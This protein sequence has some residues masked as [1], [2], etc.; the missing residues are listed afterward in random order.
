MLCMCMLFFPYSDVYSSKTGRSQKPGTGILKGTVRDSMTQ[1]PL[2]QANI[3]IEGTVIG[4]VTDYEGRFIL[5]NLLPGIYTVRVSLLGYSTCV[6][7]DVKIR[8]GETTV[9]DINLD[10][11]VIEIAP[12]VVTASKREQV[13]Q[14]SPV[15]VEVLTFRQL[16]KMNVYTVDQALRYVSGVDIKEGE[17]GIRASTGFSQGAGSRVLLLVDGNPLMA[18]DTETIKWDVIPINDI[19]R[20]EIMKGAGSALYGSNAMGGVINIITKRP[21]QTPKAN[22]KLSYGFYGEPMYAEWKWTDSAMDFNGVDVSYSRRIGKSGILSSLGRKSSDGYCQN[23]DFTRWNSLLKWNYAF[24]PQKQLTLMGIYATDEWGYFRWWKSQKEALHAPKESLKDRVQSDKINMNGSYRQVVSSKLAYLFKGYY[25]QTYWKNIFYDNTDESR[26]HRS[27]G[28]FRVD[29]I[30]AA[31]HSFT[32]GIEGIYNTVDSDMFDNHHANDFA[33]FIQ[34]GYTFQS[35][36]KTSLGI[37]YD[38]HN[39]D[40]TLVEGEI[41]PKFGLVY[42]QNEKT[43]LRLSAGRGFRAPS[44]AEMFTETNLGGI[45]VIPNPELKAE[46]VWSYEVGIHHP[47]GERLFIDVALFQNDYQDMIE[48]EQTISA[49]RFAN[50]TEA[51]VRGCEVN[52][53]SSLIHKLA[54][55]KGGYTYVDPRNRITDEYLPYRSRHKLILSSSTMY[56]RFLLDITF[57]YFSRVEA[58]HEQFAQDERVGRYTF[59]IKYGLEL[60]HFSV[61][62]KIDNLLQYNYTDVP[63]RMAPIRNYTLTLNIDF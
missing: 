51:R 42:K 1:E 62:G 21:S 45:V 34:D 61:L 11:S 40:G 7:N 53:S 49:F 20:I 58:V 46:T 29:Y 3:F 56:R 18:G 19:E 47:L 36:M 25:Y 31:R 16:E 57:S 59:D 8:A 22:I 55:L 41:S 39:V 2:S 37:R 13:L 48:V 17:V 38:Y 32:A 6:N 60:G 63:R 30:P 24:S 28:E 50:V 23:S 27:G 4:A 44:I 12:I 52:V 10:E 15:S 33:G 43:T 35:K 26:S 9:V 14:D 54:T 5:F